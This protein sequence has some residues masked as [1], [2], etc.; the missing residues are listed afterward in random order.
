MAIDTSQA[1]QVVR[2][3]HYVLPRATVFARMIASFWARA[4]GGYWGF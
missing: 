3:R 1:E 4:E 2:G